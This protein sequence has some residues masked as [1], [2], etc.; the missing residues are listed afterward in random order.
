[1]EEERLNRA[2]YMRKEVLN[3]LDMLHKAG[4]SGEGYRLLLYITY[5]VICRRQILVIF[6]NK[7]SDSDESVD[8]SEMALISPHGSYFEKDL[9]GVKRKLLVEIIDTL[10]AMHEEQD[11]RYSSRLNI[12]DY[13]ANSDSLQTRS[14]NNLFEEVLYF[15]LSHSYNSSWM[16][17]LPIELSQF[18]VDAFLQEQMQRVYNPFGGLASLALCDRGRN[19][20]DT[21]ESNATTSTVAKMRLE[22][23]GNRNADNVQTGDSLVSI[24]KPQDNK[25]DLVFAAP[26][27]GVRV[28]AAEYA[29]GTYSYPIKKVEHLTAVQSLHM[30]NK[31]GKSIV[32]LPL[33]FYSGS[34]TEKIR[35]YLLDHNYLEMIIEFPGG[36]LSYSSIPFVMIV[37]SK[38]KH[39]TN[40][41][42][43][44]ASAYVKMEGRDRVLDYRGLTDEVIRSGV[45]SRVSSVES[46]IEQD[47]R[48]NVKLQFLDTDSIN[49][50]DGER[51][52]VIGDFAERAK[53]SRRAKD[54]EVYPLVKV[55][56]LGG[57]DVS[58]LIKPSDLEIR[59][60]K[61]SM[62][63]FSSDLLL[64]STVGSE[65]KV[66]FI[67]ANSKPYT[68]L[69]HIAAMALDRDQ[70]DPIYIAYELQKDYVSEQ[71]SAY[72]TG[73]AQRFVRVGDLLKLK[74]KLPSL[75][76]QKAKAQQIR[77]LA[78][79]FDA[80]SLMRDKL[81]AG[82]E[83]ESK[84]EF[85]S[86][87]HSLGT[88]RQ[89]ILSHAK[90]LSSFFNSDANDVS[91]IKDRF[92]D[93]FG[94][95]LDTAFQEIADSIDFISML[96]E[97]GEKGLVLQDCQKSLLAITDLEELFKSFSAGAYSFE[98][99]VTGLSDM[100][101]LEEHDL[102]NASE[103]SGS[104]PELE[105]TMEASRI[106]IEA[107][108]DLFKVLIN[109]LLDNAEKHGYEEGEAMRVAAVFE[110]L[111]DQLMI[112]VAN[113]GRRFPKGQTKQ[114]F[115][116]KY[117]TSNTSTGQGLGGYDIDRI[118][119]YFGGSWDLDLNP[120]DGNSVAF[121]F[122]FPLKTLSD[123]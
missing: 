69:S 23:A 21:E 60:S 68:T 106:A 94:Y 66:A 67:E 123:V 116:R 33:S 115:I 28:D 88:P 18:V 37:L 48:C 39:D 9:R 81:L 42:F 76:V 22:V 41:H 3:V 32:L 43:V 40:V 82:Q 111:D 14:V 70:V 50:N 20:I 47:Y 54:D 120:T 108:T 4:F 87:K 78:D 74:I 91:S 84:N 46:L 97:N 2:Y 34:V 110:I 105:I 30:L 59:P 92:L 71:M 79:K 35:E 52:V 58:P 122:Q 31:T 101:L 85:A 61:G 57:E 10:L 38:D 29:L 86:L 7:L 93:F 118:V 103:T 36:L 112:S 99:F 53:G 16:G 11:T 119:R 83:I 27:F 19:M 75:A 113:N 1:M 26:P 56:D 15:T 121:T 6:R 73:T 8:L 90:V 63:V 13:T 51:L 96:L 104:H 49:L 89:N 117:S 72:S 98:W 12:D 25:Y 44:D 65:V 80:L 95:S 77:E 24:G 45:H 109:N 114:S 62:K 5:L 64:F 100:E 107:N 55:S 102:G 17:S